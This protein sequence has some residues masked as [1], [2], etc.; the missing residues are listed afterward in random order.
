MSFSENTVLTLKFIPFIFNT[1]LINTI[2]TLKMEKTK[3]YGGIIVK[4]KDEVL[5]CK[6]NNEGDLPGVW[7]IPAGKLGKTESALIGAKREFFEE[8]NLKIDNG[9]E[10]VGFIN[11]KT[12]DG[13]S[14]KG[15][16]YVFLHNVN[17]K[18]YPD[19]LNAIDGEE[20]TECG[21]FTE[22]D[23]PM[24]KNDQLYY[25]IKNIFKKK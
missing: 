14:T 17:E 22:Y 25:L 18:I 2:T 13:E 16:M 9:I 3:R 1:I 15:L 11:R 23:L 12:R 6:R 7:S 10:L 5:L 19:L 8:T 20:H 24:D 4:C 21:Y